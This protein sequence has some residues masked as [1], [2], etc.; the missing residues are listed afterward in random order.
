MKVIFKKGFRDETNPKHL[1][2]KP[3]EIEVAK[4]P[5]AKYNCTQ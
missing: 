2:L 3:L 5:C 1:K 4:L